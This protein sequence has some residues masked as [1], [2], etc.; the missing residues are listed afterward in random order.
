MV[1]FTLEAIKAATK[2]QVDT[3]ILLLF[4]CLFFVYDTI[5]IPMVTVKVIIFTCIV[6]SVTVCGTN[7]NQ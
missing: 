3:F 6:Y 4:C 5:F 1:C 7:H 2:I